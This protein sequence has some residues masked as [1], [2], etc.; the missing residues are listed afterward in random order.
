MPAE[1][2]MK[3]EVIARL[4]KDSVVD[5]NAVLYRM[6]LSKRADSERDAQWRRTLAI[7][8]SLDEEGK[9]AILAL[10]RR[11]AIDS[12]ANVV[13]IFENVNAVGSLPGK[14]ALLH[15]GIAIDGLQDA[16]LELIEHDE[17]TKHLLG[18]T[19]GRM[20]HRAVRQRPGVRLAHRLS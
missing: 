8:A 16:F 9:E 15:D 6:M 1:E 10:T 17:S 20:G 11:V 5:A 7:F 14:F 18:D 3:S 13:G 2:N 12:C 19:H 4:L